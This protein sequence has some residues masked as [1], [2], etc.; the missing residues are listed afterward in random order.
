MFV[1]NLVQLYICDF[2]RTVTNLNL[3]PSS[4]VQLEGLS[5]T[6]RLSDATKI[7]SSLL[8]SFVTSYEGF[9][10]CARS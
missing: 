4:P 5:S 1:D 6:A 10:R 3:T 7:Y 9:S 2:F 8:T